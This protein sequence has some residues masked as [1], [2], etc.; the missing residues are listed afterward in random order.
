MGRSKRL[1]AFNPGGDYFRI[2][3]RRLLCA[4]GTKNDKAAFLESYAD[5]LSAHLEEWTVT[6][7]GSLASGRQA[8]LCATE[9]S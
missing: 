7:E 1:F 4:G 5:F 2:Y 8:L 9:S 6:T 3:L